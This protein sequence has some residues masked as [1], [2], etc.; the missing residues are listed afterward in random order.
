MLHTFYAENELFY[1]ML[2]LKIAMLLI[3]IIVII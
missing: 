2:K 1:V 3:M